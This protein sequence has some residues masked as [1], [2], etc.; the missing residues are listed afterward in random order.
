MKI[1]LLLLVFLFN[2]GASTAV[3]TVPT[4]ASLP[5]DYL[6]FELQVLEDKLEGGNEA[7]EGFTI[8]M[9]VPWDFASREFEHED[10]LTLVRENKVEGTL[11]YP[12]GKTT[13]IE[14]EVVRHR[15]A[16]EIYMKTTLGYF[17]WEQVYIQDDSLYFVI[18]WW[19]QPPAQES[20][21]AVINLTEQLLA[22]PASWQ[23]EDDRQCDEDALQNKWSLFC[24]LKHASI[25]IMVEYNH[26]NTA[27]QM[28]R[29]VIDELVPDHGYAHT[30]MDYN[31]APATTH[32]DIIEVLGITA[33]RLNKELEKNNS[34]Q[35]R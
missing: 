7:L 3:D 27:M 25:E 4:Q 1:F 24:A 16:D 11:T 15:G 21:L 30:L 13:K 19:Y 10:L 17:L 6:L 2:A 22:D 12:H 23:K 33:E 34:R 8:S 26:H 9:M 5:E 32:K 35:K 29:F 14:Y 18:Y 20:D 31:N 28:V